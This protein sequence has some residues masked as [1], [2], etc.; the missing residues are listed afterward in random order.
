MTHQL[1]DSGW[2]CTWFC[3]SIGVSSIFVSKISKTNSR[4]F[5]KF[6]ADTSYT[7]PCKV[8]IFRVDHIQDEWART[9][10]NLQFSYGQFLRGVS[11]AL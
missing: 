5:E 1:Y 2:L 8:L 4:I 11:S 10:K 9:A 3:L 7:V 6:T